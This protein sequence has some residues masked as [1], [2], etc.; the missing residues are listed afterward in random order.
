MNKTL[1]LFLLLGL[2]VGLTAQAVCPVCTVAVV[3]GAGFSKMLG[4]DD[5]ITGLWIGAVLVSAALWTIEWLN[6][7]KIKFI[8]RK[9]L[10]FLVWILMFYYSLVW[11]NLVGSECDKIWGYPKLLVGMFIGAIIF[12]I[13]MIAEN[14]LRKKNAGEVYMYFQKVIIPTSFVCLASLVFY[15]LTK[16]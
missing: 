15:F 13:G 11:A 16:C 2:F 3:A 12:G 4:I 7:K 6:S 1:L 5:T 14:I 9:P 8:G 10:V